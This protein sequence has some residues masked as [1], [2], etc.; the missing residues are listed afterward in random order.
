[1]PN[2]DRAESHLIQSGQHFDEWRS[3]HAPVRAIRNFLTEEDG[4]AICVEICPGLA[5][6]KALTF[7]EAQELANAIHL[8]IAGIY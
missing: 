4:V 8:A 2:Q 6:R 1:M 3:S 7:D 5:V